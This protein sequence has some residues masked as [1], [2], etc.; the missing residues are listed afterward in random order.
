MATKEEKRDM[1][2]LMLSAVYVD[3]NVDSIVGYEPQPEFDLLFRQTTMSNTD[4]GRRLLNEN[5]ERDDSCSLHP[6][7]LQPRQFANVNVRTHHCQQLE[8]RIP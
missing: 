8:T 4:S 2:H 5:E 7:V 6:V 3:T 1:L